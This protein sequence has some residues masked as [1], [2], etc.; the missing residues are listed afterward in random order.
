MSETKIQ[1]T[2]IRWLLT[3]SRG[4]RVA[5]LAAVTARV[6]NQLLLIAVLLCAGQAILEGALTPWIWW[7]LGLSALKA[8]LRYAE[9]YAGHWVAFTVLTRMRTRFY[10]ALVPQ[11]PAVAKGR[12]AAELSE[13]ATRDIDRIEVFFAHTIPPVIAAAVVPIFA[14]I[15]SA[16]TLGAPYAWIIGVASVLVVAVPLSLRRITWPRTQAVGATQAQVAINLGDSLQGLREVAAF[17]AGPR[18]TAQWQQLSAQS[19]PGRTVIWRTAGF[20]AATL[21]AIELVGLLLLVALPSPWSVSGAV[22]GA[23]VWIGL[24][25]PLRGVDDFADGL[26]DALESAGRVRETIERA[27]AVTDRAARINATFDATAPLVEV[28]SVTFR[29][30][31]DRGFGDAALDQVSTSIAA[32]VWSY[33]AGVSG[34]GKSTLAALVGRGW[35]PQSGAVRFRGVDVRDL[36]LSQLRSHVALVVQRPYLLRGSVAQNLRLSAPHADETE[37]WKALRAVDLDGW[38]R[39][40]PDG[41]LQEISTD[42]ANLSG[43]QIQRLAIARALVGQPELLVLDEATSQLDETTATTVRARVRDTY[44]TL[45]VLEI[46]HQ[47]DRIPGDASVLVVDNGTLVEGGVAGE[48]LQDPEGALSR[49]LA[50]A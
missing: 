31:D 10:D 44:P 28:D 34:S 2:N 21:M 14:V 30:P 23:L 15:W 20:R 42:G 18:R 46:S 50:R 47:V 49:L 48:L 33:V 13:R 26:D 6:L 24:W 22:L 45:T 38:A 8:L 17:N 35:D 3:Q 29:Y 7:V 37:L 36:P 32:G 4:V 11:A 5:W 16:L 43:G 12:G 40:L 41:L 9:H 19:L 25:S 27:P 39:D 1:T